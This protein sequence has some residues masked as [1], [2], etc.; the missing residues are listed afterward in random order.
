MRITI[1]KKLYFYFILSVII[2]SLISSGFFFMRYRAELD[3]GITGKLMTGAVISKAFIDL[4]KLSEVH[5]PGFDKS[6]Y[7][8]NLLRSFKFVDRGFGFIYTY[9]MTKEDGK[10]IFVFDSGNYEPEDDY[11]NSFLTEYTDYPA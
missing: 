4:K 1:G 10:Y 2:T 9:V 8:I 6:D 3:N 7:Y 11:E 5:N